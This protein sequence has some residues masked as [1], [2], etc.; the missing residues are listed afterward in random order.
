M[1]KKDLMQTLQQGVKDV[2]RSDRW[3][4]YLAFCAK[5]HNYSHSNIMLILMQ[6]PDATKVAGFHTWRKIFGR[7]VNKGEK[8]I[9]ILAPVP[10]KIELESIAGEKILDTQMHFRTAFVFDVS[11]TSGKELPRAIDDLG[12]SV[13]GYAGVLSLL[14][15]VAPFSVEIK[16]I[17]SNAK[18]FCDFAKEIICVRSG[19]SEAQTV[20]TLIHEIAHAG[21]HDRR[22]RD[23]Q[24]KNAVD[25]RTAEV[26]AES[27]AFVVC[28]YLGIDSS[29][30][31][32]GYIA[33]WSSGKETP[34]LTR[35]LATIQQH[36]QKI[37]EDIGRVQERV[38]VSQNTQS[39]PDVPASIDAPSPARHLSN[40]T[41][42]I[43]GKTRRTKQTSVER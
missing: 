12:A 22:S 15:D 5:F 17:K 42:D 38:R 8:G 32:F 39:V 41:V 30:Y 40:A 19:M 27:I 26:E 10:Y 13:T 14:K 28:N 31:T 3:K 1:E 37:I 16:E 33:G 29:D 43:R 9:A 4:Q 11:Q 18:G 25:R 7:T 24:E 23:G 34:E 35:S 6:R 21:L 20:K 2:F 36:S